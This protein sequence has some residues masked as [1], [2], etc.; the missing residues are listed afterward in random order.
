MKI[1]ISLTVD[2]DPEAWATDNGMTDRSDIRADV[3]TWAE[4]LVTE[5]LRDQ[6]YLTT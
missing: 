4:Y 3:K 2:I 5:T 1:A 6:G